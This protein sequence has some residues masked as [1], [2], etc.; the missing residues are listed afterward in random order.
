[1]LR[2]L[3]VLVVIVGAVAGLYLSPWLD[4]SWCEKQVEDGADEIDARCQVEY[5]T[6]LISRLQNNTS[7]VMI[8]IFTN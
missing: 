5:H 2:S 1:M 6:P 8:I 7:Q 4:A 3:L